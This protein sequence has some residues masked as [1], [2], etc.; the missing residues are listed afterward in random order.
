M[1][2]VKTYRVIRDGLKVG[3]DIRN[4]G[5][6]MPEAAEFENLRSLLNTDCLEE[7]W[8]EDAALE[9]WK[10]EYAQRS[11]ETDADDE[12]SLD[13]VTDESDSEVTVEPK[14]TVPKK[15][16]RKTKKSV[17]ETGNALAE[18]AV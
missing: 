9:E 14:K 10:E 12:D 1:A 15:I 8:V 7:V 5:D 11:L 13:E 4:F 2:M 3:H 18:E 16:K 6:Y 17:K